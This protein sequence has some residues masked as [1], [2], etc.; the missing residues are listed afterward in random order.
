MIAAGADINAQDIDGRIPLHHALSQ[1]AFGQI[2]EE[3][4]AALLLAGADAHIR[5]LDGLTPHA[6][7]Q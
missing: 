4:T 1:N 5:D 3:L 6:L 7:M 2:D